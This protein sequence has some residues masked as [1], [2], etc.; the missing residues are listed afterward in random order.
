M[1][2]FLITGCAGFI[3]SSFLDHLIQEYSHKIILG[4]IEIDCVDNFSTGSTDNLVHLFPFAGNEDIAL[5]ALFNNSDRI[6]LS[7]LSGAIKL[8]F[9]DITTARFV[10]LLSKGGRLHKE[11]DAIFHFAALPRIQPSFERPVEHH[12]TNV[13][14]SL[15]LINF[16]V[17]NEF[18]NTV[19]V[20]ASSSAVYGNNCDGRAYPEIN[21]LNPYALQK[22]EVE[23]YLEVFSTRYKEFKYASMRFFNPYGKRSFNPKNKDNAYSSVIGIFENAVKNYQPVQVTGDGTQRRDFV[24][25]DDVCS[26]MLKAYQ[27]YRGNN[28]FDVGT[29]STYSIIDIAN[30][31]SDTIEFISKRE[32][33]A[34]ITCAK[35]EPTKASLGWNPTKTVYEYINEQKEKTDCP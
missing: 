15:N 11:Y 23:E 32:G 30:R 34:E 1:Q 18:W 27:N 13:V 5:P 25:V 24:H 12:M 10:D 6:Y 7:K 33:E 2:R 19:F 26:A 31:F 21:P 20:Y 14:G 9:A 22:Y 16:V 3:G 8:F 28:W 4:E 17:K 35:P 29:G